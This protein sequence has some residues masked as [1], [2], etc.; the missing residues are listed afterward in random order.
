[1]KVRERERTKFQIRAEAKMREENA[2]RKIKERQGNVK[3]RKERERDQE[4]HHPIYKYLIKI[5][6][7]LGG[8]LKPEF[9]RNH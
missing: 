9:T 4:C 1:M 6:N 2:M 8:F 5:I 3:E 7:D